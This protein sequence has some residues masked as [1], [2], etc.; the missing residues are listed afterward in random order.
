MHAIPTLLFAIALSASAQEIGPTGPPAQ[1]ESP[2]QLRAT[3]HSVWPTNQTF[4]RFGRLYFVQTV[5]STR[6]ELR[7]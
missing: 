5:N 2:L 1:P 4:E 7:A 3:I 6:R